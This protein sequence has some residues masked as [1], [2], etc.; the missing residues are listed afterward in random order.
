[1]GTD[2]GE[3]GLDR[4][5]SGLAWRGGF[6]SIGDIHDLAGMPGGGMV[7]DLS[8]PIPDQPDL[9]ALSLISR[10]SDTMEQ[11]IAWDLG[12]GEVDY[13]RSIAVEKDGTVDVL[14]AGDAGFTE[15]RRYSP[16]GTELDLSL[17]HIYQVAPAVVTAVGADG[18]FRPPLDDAPDL[19]A[20]ASPAPSVEAHHA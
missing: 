6:M 3:I 20:A 13:V 14:I 1:M 18:L 9:P 19:P 15:I 17:I 7:M 12:L 16:T 2:T 11:L 4:Y 5:S 10:L 8:I